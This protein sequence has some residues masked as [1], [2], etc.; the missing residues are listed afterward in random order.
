MNTNDAISRVEKFMGSKAF[1]KY[2]ASDG[3]REYKHFCE[4]GSDYQPTM[5]DAAASMY[6]SLGAR[7][8]AS[9]GITQDIGKN[10]WIGDHR[11]GPSRLSEGKSRKD[12]TISMW[13]E[14]FGTAGFDVNRLRAEMDAALWS[15]WFDK[16]VTS[17]LSHELSSTNYKR[18]EDQFLQ[19]SCSRKN[20]WW[21]TLFLRIKEAPS[22]WRVK[23]H[24]RKL[25]AK[26]ASA[27]QEGNS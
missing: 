14:D 16:N 15:G 12:L 13:L 23:R 3:V 8:L 19:M 1:A 7:A 11:A 4:L 2:M 10:W 27:Q 17:L 21:R 24:Y 18:Q 9:I 6:E 25:E 26:R 20:P 5:A 22:N